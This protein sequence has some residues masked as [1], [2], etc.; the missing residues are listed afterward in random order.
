VVLILVVAVV[1]CRTE[2]RPAPQAA[3]E[4]VEGVWQTEGY[5]GVLEITSDSVQMFE[6]TTNYCLRAGTARRIASI[7]ASISASGSASGSASDAPTFESDDIGQFQVRPGSSPGS[8][9]LHVPGAASE[10]VIHR[11]PDR[12]ATCDRPVPNTPASNLEVFAE[13][14][15]EHYILFDD[16]RV[17]WPAVVAKA[18]A[19]VT[20]ASTPKELFAILRDMIEPLH[21]AHTFVRAPELEERFTGFRPGVERFV[22]GGIEDFRTVQIPRITAVTDRYLREPIQPW[23]NGRV[24]YASI[25]DVTGYLRILG[26]YGY[27]EGPFE[28]SVAAL[29]AA[30]DVVMTDLARKK[31]LVIDVRVNPGGADPLGLAIASRLTSQEYRAYS[32]EARRD[33]VDRTKWTPGQPSVVRPS[34]RPSFQGEVIELIGPLTISAGETFTQALMG[35]KPKVLR[36]GEPTQGVFSDVLVRR[37][38]NGWSFGLPNE[39]F[40]TA[41]GRTFDGPGIPP[42]VTVP[43]FSER[44]LEAGRD[45]ALEWLG[46]KRH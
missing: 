10:I 39:V 34:D 11:I 12:P 7:S 1:G 36:V 35:R 2:L 9:R 4:P 28:N 18:R 14:W 17:D 38:P 16:K 13:T 41:D 5:G 26:F 3:T 23:C 29:D 22:Q 30:L 32:K 43:V 45:T 15:A 31:R 40:R 46:A 33:P 19:R 21:D 42:D 24:Q 6:V 8:K 27:A 37:L 44:D 20:P 25:D